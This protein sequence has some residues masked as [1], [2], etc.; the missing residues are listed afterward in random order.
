MIRVMYKKG[1]VV[2]NST[3]ILLLIHMEL[4]AG[5][6]SPITCA[7][8]HE[9]AVLPSTH[10]NRSLADTAAC[11]DC[12]KSN[13]EAQPIGDK[14]H[15][16]HSA[17]NRNTMND[18]YACHAVTANGMV[19]LPGR[20]VQIN[21]SRVSSL[22]TF[23]N[24]WMADGS[25]RL[26]HL[27]KQRGVTCLGCHLDYSSHLQ[28]SKVQCKKCHGDYDEMILKTEKSSYENN[29]HYMPHIPGLQ[30]EACH[31]AHKDFEDI[32]SPC[33]NYGYKP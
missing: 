18:C 30:C 2:L 9:V 5:P 32:C 25:N 14:I 3:F 4:C 1:L 11:F 7:N 20:A 10:K 24:S 27:H 6:A 21:E 8:C 12:H 28:A 17:G 15:L 23:F 31:H 26:D 13:G 29:P 33:H 22:K 16:L 19:E